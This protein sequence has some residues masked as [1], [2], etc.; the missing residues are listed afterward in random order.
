M[1][2]IMMTGHPLA[3][4]NPFSPSAGPGRTPTV[5]KARILKMAIATAMLPFA[6]AGCA[7][8]HQAHMAISHSS[9]AVSKYLA[10]QRGLKGAAVVTT[11][12]TPFLMGM[13]VHISHQN[14]LPAMFQKTIHLSTNQPLSIGQFATQ[15]TQM[16]GIPIHVASQVTGYLDASVMASESLKMMSGGGLPALPGQSSPLMLSPSLPNM[17][18]SRNALMINWNGTLSGLLNLVAART[19][20]YWKYQNGKVRFFLTETRAFSVDALPGTTGLTANITNSG[21]NGSAGG[22]GGTTGNSGST[23]QAATVATSL[24]IYKSIISGIQTVLAQSKAASGGGTS[25][26]VPTS[27]SANESTG[28]I[29][30]TASPSEL[31]AVAAYLKPVNIEMA[32]NVMIDVHV[33]SVQLNQSNN[34]N[35]N[36]NVALNNKG[37]GIQSLTQNGTPSNLQG[38]QTI[39]GPSGQ[40][41]LSAG[42]VTGPVNAQVVATALATQGNV[43]LV[44]SG[45]IIALNGQPTPLQVANMHSYV[46]SSA[47]TQTAQVGSSTSLTPGQFSTGFSGT[48]LPLVRGHHIL[49]EYTINLTQNLGLQTFTSGTSTV[50]LPNLAMQA[51]MQRVSIKSGQTLVLSGFEQTKSQMDRGGIGSAHFWGLGGGAGAVHDKTALVIV[52][53]IVKLGN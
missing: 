46:A 44:T 12:N 14:R 43:S 53:H 32:K 20:T 11:V 47:T 15:I 16:T 7:T 33:Y 48:F 35:L 17:S 45:S 25:V 52:I 27:V 28:Q 41:S 9:T 1:R 13:V 51:F 2:N 34:Y 5:N 40:G 31:R 8:F 3:G 6:L 23:S 4:C 37:Y 42:I 10:K 26:Q 49:L 38:P 29:I 30:V 21:T 36:L 22:G 24:D 19:G 18:S 50:Q 39:S